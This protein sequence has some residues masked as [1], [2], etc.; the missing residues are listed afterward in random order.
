MIIATEVASEVLPWWWT[1]LGVGLVV[2]IVVVAL[3]QILL[4]RVHQ[5]EDGV[6]AIWARG[7]EVAR[8]TAT[9]WMIGGTADAAED[10]L[11]EAGRHVALLDAAGRD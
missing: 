9:V 4:T 1:A 5:I 11:E 10:I 2:A 6:A 7:Q 3:L 8:N